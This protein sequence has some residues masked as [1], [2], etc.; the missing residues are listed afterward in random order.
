MAT[1][2]VFGSHPEVLAFVVE[3]LRRAGY[4]VR[5]SLT[6]E[7]TLAILARESID[8][9]VLGGPTAHAAADEVIAALKARHPYAAVL[10]PSSPEDVLV[11]VNRC[12]AED[13]S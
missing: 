9:L 4:G 8:A 1:I 6:R 10:Y 2:L 3:V 13:V 7:D 5:P 12:F 11:Q